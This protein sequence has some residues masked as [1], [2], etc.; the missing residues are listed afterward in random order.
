M[1]DA[2]FPHKGI[3]A[4]FSF[5]ASLSLFFLLIIFLAKRYTHKTH[6]A[7][8]RITKALFIQTNVA[9]PQN[10]KA[11]I[12]SQILP[13]NSCN[14][15]ITPLSSGLVY[16]VTSAEVTGDNKAIIREIRKLKITIA[17]NQL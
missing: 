4:I 11:Q 7:T 10:H 8:H 17:I 13:T 3:C 6:N 1:D 12:I 5:N 14:P 9:N 16:Q 15:D 2:Y